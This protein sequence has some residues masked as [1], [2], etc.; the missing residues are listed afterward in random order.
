M[1]GPQLGAAG[2]ESADTIMRG[3]AAPG[4]AGAE[5]VDLAFAE[6]RHHAWRR[7][8][9]QLHVAV[10]IDTAQAQPFPQ[11]VVLAREGVDHGQPW[12]AVGLADPGTHGAGAVG[13]IAAQ[14]GAALLAEC[15]RQH[16]GIAVTAQGDGRQGVAGC[17]LQPQAHGQRHGREHLR[18]IEQ[19]GGHLVAQGRPGILP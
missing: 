2:H 5:A 18:A 6:R 9:D 17:A 7:Q 14:R 1:V 4:F 19:P 15:R 3:Q 12:A 16:D 11:Q 8:D 10:G 13:G